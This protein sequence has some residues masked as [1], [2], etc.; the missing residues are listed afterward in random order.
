MKLEELIRELKG[1]WVAASILAAF[2]TTIIADMVASPPTLWRE[3]GQTPE[4]INFLA[5]IVV[6]AGIGS[7]MAGRSLEQRAT[8]TRIVPL[9]LVFAIVYFLLNAQ[10][11]CPFS[12][13]RMATGWTYLADAANH[14]A[15]NPGQGCS[16]LIADFTG[17]TDK[18]WPKHEILIVW[19]A[20]FLIYVMA[21]TLL[22]TTIL[23]VMQ[24]ISGR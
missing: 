24:H 3:A 20:L 10:L 14:L 6:A 21:V 17:N 7:V 9:A 1:S 5:T 16:L 12:G 4:V 18:I 2:V 22:A 19:V 13:N 11:S 23:R 15:K 8:F